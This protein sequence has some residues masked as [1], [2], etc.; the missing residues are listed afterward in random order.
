[1][2]ISEES[3]NARTAVPFAIISSAAIA[4]LVGWGEM[5]P[6]CKEDGKLMS[7][8]GINM[9]LVFNMGTDLETIV[10][11]PIGQPLATVRV[12]R[13]AGGRKLMHVQIFLNSF[14]KQGTLALWSIII[15]VQYMM[16]SSI[17]CA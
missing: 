5:T 6:Q 1:M 8:S 16:G 7:S 15:I 12:L 10:S 17:V 2:H 4:G 14:G 11:N 13:E 9:A 3:T